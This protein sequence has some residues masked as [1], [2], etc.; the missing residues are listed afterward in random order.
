M[1]P[2]REQ[3]EARAKARKMPPLPAPRS[4]ADAVLGGDAIY[5]RKEVSSILLVSPGAI[6]ADIYSRHRLG[7]LTINPTPGVHGVVR[8]R[9]SDLRAYLHA[10]DFLVPPEEHA[11]RSRERSSRR[12]AKRKALAAS[13]TNAQSSIPT[14]SNHEQ[15]KQP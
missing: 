7:A 11:T 9:R 13:T 1:R 3:V 14:P 8:V 15:E 4:R 5:T 12:R 2:T 10:T 6:G